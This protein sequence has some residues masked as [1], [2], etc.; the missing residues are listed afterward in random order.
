MSIG[1]LADGKSMEQIECF[2]NGLI[3]LI[4]IEELLDKY[5]FEKN[6]SNN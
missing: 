6:F 5:F 2:F 3:K 4:D 1:L